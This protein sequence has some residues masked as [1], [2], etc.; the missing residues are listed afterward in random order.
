MTNNV[1]ASEVMSYPPTTLNCVETVA[2]IVHVLQTETC[3]GFPV[4]DSYLVRNVERSEN[5]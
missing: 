2:R 3:N 5:S 1:Y 4:V